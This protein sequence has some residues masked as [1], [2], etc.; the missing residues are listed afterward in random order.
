MANRSRFEEL[1]AR[2]REAAGEL[3]DQD[4]RPYGAGCE[5]AAVLRAV[6][7]ELED[8]IQATPLEELT[9]REAA[10]ESGYSEWHLRELIRNGTINARRNGLRWLIQRRDLPQRPGVQRY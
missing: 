5:S 2:W 6:A 9:V 1:V 8:A 10:G 7:A 4:K 3:E